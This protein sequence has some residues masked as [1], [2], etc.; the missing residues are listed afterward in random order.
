MLTAEFNGAGIEAHYAQL[1]A[2]VRDAVRPAAQAGAQVFYD[3]VRLRAPRS[4]KA[5]ST[6][7]KRYTFQP[8]NL[9]R[10]CL[11]YTS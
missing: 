3:E 4:E 11:L 6:K 5:H 7:G 9:Q 8:G 2:K 1:Q 10:A